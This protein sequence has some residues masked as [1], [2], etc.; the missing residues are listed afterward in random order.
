MIAEV[1]S[2]LHN[3]ADGD[4][5]EQEVQVFHQCLK[6][7]LEV[8]RQRKLFDFELEKI[9]DLFCKVKDF[10]YFYLAYYGCTTCI[11]YLQFYL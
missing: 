11:E 10:N 9:Y 3:L 4:I 1:T 8:G 5:T 2:E 6:N 7:I